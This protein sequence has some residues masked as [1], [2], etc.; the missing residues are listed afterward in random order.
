MLLCRSGRC[1]G[2]RRSPLGEEMVESPT[3]VRR[4]AAAVAA[5]PC[6]TGIH[7]GNATAV[8]AF[9]EAIDRVRSRQKEELRASRRGQILNKEPGG[10]K[11][12]CRFFWHRQRRRRR[13][14]KKKRK[15]RRRGRPTTATAVACVSKNPLSRHR[16]ACFY[17]GIG[18][19]NGFGSTL[20]DLL[21]GT[22]W[23]FRVL[24]CR[25]HHLS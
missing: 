21:R 13:A 20:L 7:H 6:G 24:C 3:L 18:S 23:D 10:S 19:A 22:S 17:S 16:R 25:R 1:G 14:K 9:W 15:T 11:R 8:F 2:R 5:A 4:T 12:L